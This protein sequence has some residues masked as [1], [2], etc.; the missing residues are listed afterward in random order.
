MNQMSLE[1]LPSAGTVLCCVD[2]LSD[3][4]AR[5]FVFGK[6]GEQID[7]F[8]VRRGNEIRAYLNSCPHIGTPLE[9]LT[10]RFLTFDNQMILCST[11]GAQFTIDDGLCVMGPCKGQSLT[12]IATEVVDGEVRLA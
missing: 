12:P 3:P 2:A 5:G 4:G 8:V 9:T 1:H 7:L 10:D 11:H 6:G